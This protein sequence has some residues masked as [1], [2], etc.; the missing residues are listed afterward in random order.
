MFDESLQFIVFIPTIYSTAGL[1][2]FNASLK[3]IFKMKPE[4]L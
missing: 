4:Y 1:L 3:I 2:K